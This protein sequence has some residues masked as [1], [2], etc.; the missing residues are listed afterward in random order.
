MNTFAKHYIDVLLITHLLQFPPQKSPIYKNLLLQ[1]NTLNPAVFRKHSASKQIL[2]QAAIKCIWSDYYGI[3]QEEYL[4]L[5]S[6][7]YKSSRRRDNNTKWEACWR[8]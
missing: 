7:G 5:I 4:P 8:L 3:V 1:T 6:S 2:I